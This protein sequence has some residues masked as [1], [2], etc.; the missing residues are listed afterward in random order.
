MFF[1]FQGGPNS[2][3]LTE[4]D[5]K[6]HNLWCLNHS[7]AVR[8]A[9]MRRSAK[10]G[11]NSATAA[12][13][14]AEPITK[15]AELLEASSDLAEPST[16]TAEHLE[17]SY[18]FA[19]T[20]SS[21]LPS[22]TNSSLVLNQNVGTNLPNSILRTNEGQNMRQP[23]NE[24]QNIAERGLDQNISTENQPF[25]KN[26]STQKLS[27]RLNME[28]TTFESSSPLASSADQSGKHIFTI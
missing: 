16:K 2:T 17:A 14:S 22:D 20:Q 12:A 27:V 23:F 10:K 21:I 5:K 18:D 7:S 1:R 6:H 26:A 11:Q 28:A 4:F 15:T 24:N 25:S 19:D 9:A 8:R 3:T 13:T